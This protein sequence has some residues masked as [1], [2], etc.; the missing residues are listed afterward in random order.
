MKQN[1]NKNKNKLWYSSLVD[2]RIFS[3]R[4]YTISGGDMP[5][6]FDPPNAIESCG[7]SRNN[8]ISVI[9]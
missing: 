2:S 8:N 6:Y 3:T 9:R 7:S 5:S 1:N 4:A